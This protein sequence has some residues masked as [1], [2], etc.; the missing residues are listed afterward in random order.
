M[1]NNIIY[2]CKS[3]YL[4]KSII[5]DF[6]IKSFMYNSYSSELIVHFSP[7]LNYLKRLSVYG[8]PLLLPKRYVFVESAPSLI[9]PSSIPEFKHK[10]NQEGAH[11]INFDDNGVCEA[12]LV[13]KEK[14]VIDW[15]DRERQLIELCDNL[16]K[17]M[18]HMI[19]W[20]WQ[21]R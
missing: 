21:W 20:C 6:V 14:S 17:K 4:L 10:R 7:I 3:I 2:I 12:C 16:G 5:T 9:E 18:D 1:L 11:Y 13:H 8:F 19:V 15:D